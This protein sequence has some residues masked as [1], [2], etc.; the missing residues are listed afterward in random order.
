MNDRLRDAI[1]AYRN[2]DRSLKPYP[3][4]QAREAVLID[5]LHGLAA[6]YGREIDATRI[7]GNGEMAFNVIGRHGPGPGRPCGP[8][9]EELA[10]WLSTVPRRT[11]VSPTTAPV[12]PENGWCWINHFHVERLLVDVAA[13]LAPEAGEGEEPEASGPRM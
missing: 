4:G 2:L 8:Y 5:F 1:D 9:G 10:A 7:N 11:G 3:L 6:E 12:L 13:K